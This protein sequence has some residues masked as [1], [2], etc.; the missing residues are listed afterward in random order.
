MT[1]LLRHF[2]INAINLSRQARDKHRESTQKRDAF[3]AGRVGELR[4]RG[5]QQVG[6]AASKGPCAGNP[7]RSSPLARAAGLF[8]VATWQPASSVADTTRLLDYY[9]LAIIQ[10]SQI[11]PFS[12][13]ISQPG[14]RWISLTDSW[15]RI[16]I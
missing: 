9:A 2:Y 5:V 8:A 12:Q 15:Q 10:T 6:A 4:K 7:S 3:F 14:L 11:D 1:H 13:G 16:V